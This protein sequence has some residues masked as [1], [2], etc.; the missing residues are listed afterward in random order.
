MWVDPLLRRRAASVVLA[1]RN[2][3]LC[4][5]VVPLLGMTG[6][7]PLVFD[8]PTDDEPP[9]PVSLHDFHYGTA[10]GGMPLV[11]DRP[12]LAL[13]VD[14]DD[15]PMSYTN[16]ALSQLTF[17]G[18]PSLSVGQFFLEMS[19]GRFA[20]HPGEVLGPLRNAQGLFHP[21]YLDQQRTEAGRPWPATEPPPPF[22]SLRARIGGG[23]RYL[24]VDPA[25]DEVSMN[26][27]GADSFESFFVGDVNGA[28]LRG[29]DRVG[30]RT[31]GGRWL[32]VEGDR[33]VATT[34]G[35]W[36][37]LVG[38]F[39]VLHHPYTTRTT[40]VALGD[41]VQLR[42]VDGRYLYWDDSG[43]LRVSASER[44]VFY[45]DRAP[46]VPQFVAAAALRA[47]VAAG[48]DF[49][50][51][52]ANDD[53]VIA[54]DELVVL[55]VTA[56]RTNGPSIHQDY[57]GAARLLQPLT[58]GGYRF[59]ERTF[60]I[61]PEH[62]SLATMTHEISHVVARTLDVYC[63]IPTYATLMGPTIIPGVPDLR[64]VY[65]L[66]AWHKLRAGWLEPDIHEVRSELAGSARLTA[67]TRDGDRP[68]LLFD[69]TRYDVLSGRGE[70]FLI[71]HRRAE[72]YDADVHDSGIVVW[73]VWNDEQGNLVPHVNH[74]EYCT[75]GLGLTYVGVD[76][77]DRNPTLERLRP[78]RGRGGF[79]RESHGRVPLQWYDG[80]PS[81]ISIQVNATSPEYTRNVRWTFVAP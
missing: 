23:F 38:Q 43:A 34:E 61:Y 25:T 60:A 78:L 29:L 3:L 12:T 27:V 24:K 62:T 58:I 14:F 40:D 9:R 69:R 46:A 37:P 1:V 32:T 44:A 47:A 18:G 79:V 72:S 68:L 17:G 8:D 33:V 42:T 66:D 50:Q 35:G 65:H 19:D 59:G 2:V 10:N 5:S 15:E 80:S 64:R 70:Y 30:F 73:H 56:A 7:P 49:S 13:A 26:S 53:G 41:A 16:A 52:D 75:D 36:P 45:W 54:H 20:I 67:A 28:P 55:V 71:E 77:N 39:E 6:C 74:G 48:H 22:V 76:A 31:V 21:T 57:G 63:A 11:G 4:L 81:G 51:Y